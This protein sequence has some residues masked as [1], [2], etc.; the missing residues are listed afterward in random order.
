MSAKTIVPASTLFEKLLIIS[1]LKKV[2]PSRTIEPI[3]QE[4]LISQIQAEAVRGVALETGLK[5]S[6][7]LLKESERCP[8][9]RNSVLMLVEPPYNVCFDCFG[10]ISLDSN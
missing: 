9:C 5:C 2:R 3:D 4:V 7:R 8:T 6:P 1:G 10:E